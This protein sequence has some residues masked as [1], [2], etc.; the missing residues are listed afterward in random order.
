[1]K[2]TLILF[3]LFAVAISTKLYG[4]AQEIDP[5]I[6]EILKKVKSSTEFIQNM[7]YY[8]TVQRVKEIDKKDFKEYMKT[9]RF[10]NENDIPVYQINSTP[11]QMD[12]Y[13]KKGKLV[14]NFSLEKKNDLYFSQ[15]KLYTFK[16]RHLKKQGTMSFR[17]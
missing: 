1:M 13:F 5:E 2:Y 6:A 4:Q 14:Y 3:L 7:N 12:F 9:S 16:D 15:F 11:T 17:P 10:V 8:L